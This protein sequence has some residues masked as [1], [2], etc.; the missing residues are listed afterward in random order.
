MTE[1]IR[2][3][4]ARLAEEPGSLAFLELGETLRRRGQ[5]D[6][7]LKVARGGVSRYPKLVD[8]HDLIARILCDRDDLHAAFE[9]WAEALRIDP[10]HPSALKGIAFLYFRAGDVTAARQF[11]ERAIEADPDDPAISVALSRLDG[12]APSASRGTA[13]PTAPPATTTSTPPEPS[14]APADRAA[15]DDYANV[16]LADGQGMRLRGTLLGEG[17]RDWSDAVAAELAGVAKE[18]SRT[19]RFLELGGWES[20]AIESPDGH[21]VIRAPTAETAVLVARGNDVPMAQLH[22]IAERAAG[23]ARGWL[24]RGR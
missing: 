5:L 1:D 21:L 10:L 12:P 22:L 4:T 17:G 9:A 16:V 19:A 13:A 8:A 20:I 24:E 7:A 3:L 23:E 15:A 11:L 2:A 14:S 6:A 18:A